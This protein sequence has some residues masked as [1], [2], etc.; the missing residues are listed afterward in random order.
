MATRK[1]GVNGTKLQYQDW[2]GNWRAEEGTLS[3]GSG[4]RRKFW[5]E[6]DRLY[7]NEDVSG[8][9]TRYL[10]FEAIAGTGGAGRFLIKGNWVEYAKVGGSFRRWH[11]DTTYSD[12]PHDNTY[13]DYDPPHEDTHTDVSH[14]DSPHSD[15]L[16]YIDIPHS[17]NPPHTDDHVDWDFP[18]DPHVDTPY[19][20]NPPHTDTHVDYDPPHEDTHSNVS[21][22][23]SP[24]SDDLPYIDTPYSDYLPHEDGHMDR[25]DLI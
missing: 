16:P 20:D 21:Y 15:D 5:I 6:G 9:A 11:T 23:D 24:H 13:V 2:G 3:G 25:P 17:D 19:S 14:T 7:Y 12:T 4:N 22:I 8:G 10:P 1:I 18:P